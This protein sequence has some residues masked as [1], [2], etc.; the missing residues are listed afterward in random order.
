[1][2]GW[3]IGF[4]GFRVGYCP[5]SKKIGGAI[6]WCKFKVKGETAV[7]QQGVRDLGSEGVGELGGKRPKV[8]GLGPGLMIGSL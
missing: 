4:I 2:I 1:V 6:L 7:E 3:D 5:V 8:S